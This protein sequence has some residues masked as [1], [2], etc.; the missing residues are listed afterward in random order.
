MPITVNGE[1]IQ[2]DWIY[3]E[4]S[5]IKSYYE[6]TTH[7]S[8]CE[9]D[10][11][12]MD[13]ARENVVRRMLL[14]QEADRVIPHLSENEIALAIRQLKKEMGGDAGFYGHYGI[15]PSQESLIHPT[16]DQSIR[17]DK[18]VRQICGPQEDPPQEAIQQYYL[19]HIAEWTTEESIRCLHIY[20]T[21]KS[22]RNRE[23]LYRECVD[24][25][26]K[27]L[28]GGDFAEL[29]ASFTDKPVGEID[30]GWFKR[31]D[32]MEE[33]EIIAFSMEVGEVSPVF[34][35]HHGFH[36]AYLAERIPSCAKPLDEV[37]DQVVDGCRAGIREKKLQA[38]VDQLRSKA[39]IDGELDT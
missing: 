24:L 8:C 13:M 2:P 29:A 30:L 4:F 36:L 15:M 14:V 11:E 37:R 18:L 23:E 16:I 27:V 17:V 12:F 35:T 28:N 19:D 39:R 25:R 31:G 6:R 5:Q 20:K 26:K 9:R 7:A 1:T 3:E 10:P 22:D 32:I 38:F 21:F 34:S 33:F